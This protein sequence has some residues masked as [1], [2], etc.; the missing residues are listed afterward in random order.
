MQSTQYLEMIAT[1]LNAPYG[2]IVDAS[3]VAAA[4]RSGDLASV[5]GDDLARELL[6]SM[7]VELE[8]ELIGRASFEAGVRL[9]EAQ[10]L[11]QQT[12]D[13]FGLPKAARWE[14]AIEG[15]L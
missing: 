1:H 14:E 12:R 11:Y 5:S 15:V 4:L 6:A 7:F 9:E 10:R 13:L 3:D 8:P 2:Q